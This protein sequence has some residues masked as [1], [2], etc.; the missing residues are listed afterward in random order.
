MFEWL[1]H[2]E[3]D[4]AEQDGGVL[5]PRWR[6][7][8]TQAGDAARGA[9]RVL[10]GAVTGGIRGAV[11]GGLRNEA[12][13][14]VMGVDIKP[15]GPGSAF[16]L[17]GT[18]RDHGEMEDLRDL[19]SEY[20]QWLFENSRD[21]EAQILAE[22]LMGELDSEDDGPF[23]ALLP[24][25]GAAARKAL[26]SPPDDDDVRLADR[27]PKDWKPAP[28]VALPEGLAERIADAPLTDE[29]KLGQVKLAG[30]VL[31]VS[32][33]LGVMW[34]GMLVLAMIWV[35]VGVLWIPG[36]AAGVLEIIAG[37]KLRKGE[38]HPNLKLFSTLGLV[39]SLLSMN[40]FSGIAGGMA[41]IYISDD[42]LADTYEKLKSGELTMP[43]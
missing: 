43:A 42:D 6:T 29:D 11:R 1:F 2:G 35:C 3:L 5:R 19:D 26:Y 22:T 41:R 30:T 31:M 39:G 27:L 4:Q 23:E 16:K 7:G 10:A 15:M 24:G 13:L 20:V 36:I 33:I 18:K 8:S 28:G 14:K 12:K 37:A 21:K 17:V 34:N 32:G 9:G 25:Q 40:L 38:V